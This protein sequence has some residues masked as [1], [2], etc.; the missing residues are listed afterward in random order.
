MPKCRVGFGNKEGRNGLR[1]RD[2]E[3]RLLSEQENM[4][5]KLKTTLQGFIRYKGIY[6]V[7]ERSS[8]KL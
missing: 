2:S 1:T 3:K 7:V 6:D 8:G 5:E 4:R